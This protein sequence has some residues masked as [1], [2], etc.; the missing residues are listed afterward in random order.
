M[1]RFKKTRE[2]RQTLF[3]TVSLAV[4]TRTGQTV[5]VKTSKLDQVKRR[6]TSS[7]EPLLEDPRAEQELMQLLAAEGKAHRNVLQLLHHAEDS[8]SA[9]SVFEF[10]NGGELFDVIASSGRISGQ[11]AQHYVAQIALG[12]QHLHA[13]G[14][15]HLDLSLENVLVDRRA[16]EPDRLVICDFGMARRVVRGQLMSGRPGKLGCMA[17]EVFAGA[18][19]D[20]RAA[21]MFSLGVVIFMI[22]T[23]LP[24]FRMPALSDERYR[25]I[26]GGQMRRLL[27]AW[28]CGHVSSDAE[29]LLSRLLCPARSRLNIDEVLA[30]DYLADTVLKINKE[31]SAASTSTSSKGAG[32]GAGAGAG[33]GAVSTLAPMDLSEDGDGDETDEDEFEPVEEEKKSVFAF[34]SRS[35]SSAAI[36]S[37]VLENVVRAATTTSMT[38]SAGAGLGLSSNSHAS[39]TRSAVF[40]S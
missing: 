35:G 34:G 13:H 7:G 27:D 15:A 14:V 6:V 9:H 39:A 28:G 20:G 30:H 16:G 31:R 32:V 17:P 2:L 11:Q 25:L 19:F 8:V 37:S 5:A 21:D 4:D 1:D 40:P 3:G 22:L 24:P 29:D 18:A 10:M 26:T 33:A 36:V 38:S 23:G 12:L